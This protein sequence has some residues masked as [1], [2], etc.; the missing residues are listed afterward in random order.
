MP[1][2]F[3]RTSFAEYSLDTIKIGNLSL[4][5]ITGVPAQCWQTMKLENCPADQH[6]RED[7]EVERGGVGPIGG[8]AVGPRT[9]AHRHLGI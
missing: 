5:F 4:K 9:S 7:G 8:V 3:I 6:N 1:I 2:I